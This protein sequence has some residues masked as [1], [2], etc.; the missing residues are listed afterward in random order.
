MKVG[1]QILWNVAPIC[2]TSQ[3]TSMLAW[4][5]A[6]DVNDNMN[7]CDSA[8]CAPHWTHPLSAMHSSQ[9]VILISSIHMHHGSSSRNSS[10]LH[11]HVHVCGLFILIY[12]FYFFLFLPSLFLFLTNKKFMANL[13]NSVE[14]GVDTN[15]VLSFSTVT[16]AG[17]RRYGPTAGCGFGLHTWTFL[18]ET[19]NCQYQAWFAL[20]AG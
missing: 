20:L 15:D 5:F 2:E 13:Y 8:R 16:E 4:H 7:V 9:I 6:T 1:G 3:T 10:H 18:F 19:C 12:S 17:L 11:I 14:E